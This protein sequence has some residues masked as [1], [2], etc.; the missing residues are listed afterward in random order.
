M[1]GLSI[2]NL[3]ALGSEGSL[4]LDNMNIDTTNIEMR[5][6]DDISLENTNLLSGLVTVEDSDLSVRHGAL[7]NVEIQQDNGD[8]ITLLWIA[9]KWMFLTEMLTLPKVQ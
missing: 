5:D 6:G 8:C 4:K 7:C 2:A 9:V 1:Q 3:E